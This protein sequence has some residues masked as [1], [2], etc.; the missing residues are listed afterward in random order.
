MLPMQQLLAWQSLNP[1]NPLAAPEL[2]G[3]RDV[4]YT[5]QVEQQLKMMQKCGEATNGAAAKVKPE[6]K[7]R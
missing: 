4:Y 5:E 2:Q 1:R 6:P 3:A 7:W